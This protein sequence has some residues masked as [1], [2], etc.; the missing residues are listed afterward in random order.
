MMNVLTRGRVLS[1]GAS[2]LVHVALIAG[3]LSAERW[4]MSAEALRPP[5]LITEVVTVSDAPSS[6]EA[7][8]KKPE[9]KRAPSPQRGWRDHWPR[10]FR[11]WRRP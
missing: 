1:V 2:C 7:I 6:P 8:Q 3:I 10:R 5:V 9:P 4:I 11:G